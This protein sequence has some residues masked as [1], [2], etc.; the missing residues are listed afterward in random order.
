MH[1]G[2]VGVAP[3]DDELWPRLCPSVE[4]AVLRVGRSVE[5]RCVGGDGGEEV[6]C[7]LGNSAHL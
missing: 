7:V 5:D 2:Q 3:E 4:Y 1:L 6:G